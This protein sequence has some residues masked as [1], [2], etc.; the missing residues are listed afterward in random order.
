MNWKEFLVNISYFLGRLVILSVLNWIKKKLK[1]K[2]K[3][4]VTG[5]DWII[6]KHVGDPFPVTHLHSL[7]IREPK[8]RQG[9]PRFWMLDG[10]HGVR[11]SDS[12]MSPK[13]LPTFSP[14]FQNY[15]IQSSPFRPTSS[16][17][18]LLPSCNFLTS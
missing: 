5:Y 2:I 6:S 17:S 14:K 16:Q 11:F 9:Y 4:T 3:E 8:K 18:S 10:V 12:S 15:K 7:F 1:L 13:C